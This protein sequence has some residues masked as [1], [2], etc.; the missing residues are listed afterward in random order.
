MNKKKLLLIGLHL[1]IIIIVLITHFNVWFPKKWDKETVTKKEEPQKGEEVFK[2]KYDCNKN[3]IDDFTDFLIGARKEIEIGTK[4]VEDG[5]YYFSDGYPPEGI[6][7]CTD[8][9]WRA[10]KEAG[11]ILK[12]MVNE[13]IANN[14]SA[15][16]D[17]SS[18]PD[19]PDSIVDF[20]RVQNL[21]AFFDRHATSLT[22]D[23]YDTDEWKPGDIVVIGE[24][25]SHI[26]IISDKL[27]DEGIP[28]LIHNS[29]EFA[30]EQDVL[31]Y[32]YDKDG[33]SGHYR[34]ENPGN[35]CKV[36]N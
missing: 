24:R 17:P 32:R 5:G 30:G 21:K 15:Y 3:G 22:L 10:F 9:I 2:S 7:V 33:I 35:H 8:T 26:G 12:D 16:P 23:P 34:F 25:Y 14:L 13:D 18:R 31:I 20:R 28:Y 19:G 1:L 27:N 11:Y 29:D 36:G 6:G 4:Y